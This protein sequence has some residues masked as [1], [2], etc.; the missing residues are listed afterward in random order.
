MPWRPYSAASIAGCPFLRFRSSPSFANLLLS[1]TPRPLLSIVCP[2]STLGAYSVA[3]AAALYSPPRFGGLERSL[4]KM[5]SPRARRLLAEGLPS[6]RHGY[7]P[8]AVFA[9]VVPAR[10]R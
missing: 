10:R 2:H 7:S 8:V 9:C 1:T 5:T 6:H 4:F 3:T